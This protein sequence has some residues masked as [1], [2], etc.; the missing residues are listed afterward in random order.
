VV[1][2]A[3]AVRERFGVEPEQIPDLHALVGDRSDGLP[4]VPGWGTASASA[5]LRRYGSID[6]I[7]PDAEEWDVKVRGAA[8][9][10]AALAERRVEALLCRDL[11]VLRTDLPLRAQVDDLMWRGALRGP[12]AA[13]CALIE[14]DSVAARIQRWAD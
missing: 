11:A 7:P 14:D 8:R 13:L 4:G 10:A 6:A 3:P 2:D 5:L 9:L 12:I 1:T